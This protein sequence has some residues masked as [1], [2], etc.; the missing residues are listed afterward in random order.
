[1]SESVNAVEK[2]LDIL[3]CF[4]Q[5]E[6]VL[7]LTRI[8]EQVHLPKST[9][10]RHLITLENRHFLSRNENTG[11]YH[12]GLR[13]IEMAALVLRDSDFQR[14]THAHLQRLADATGETVD[15]AVLDGAHVV[16]LQVIE[17]PQR[18]KIAAAIG[19]R[20]PAY[21]TA[22]GKA[23]LAFLPGDRVDELLGQ[24]L[25]RYTEFTRV[26]QAAIH[27]DLEQTRVRGYAI[28]EQE[29][30]K[31]I[32]VV[33]APILD[34]VGYP[35]AAVAVA[36]PSF[37]LPPERMKKLGESILQTTAAIVSEGGI[38]ALSALI[39][40]SATPGLAGYTTKRGPV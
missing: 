2:A 28:S 8:A 15:L 9:V 34:A 10:H 35:V 11:M 13:F 1:M 25:V 6:P 38:T 33:A 21:C 16:D 30:E 29:Y 24:N 20:L 5:E 26:D 18:V 17:S 31:D 36:G 27:A 19:Q 4:S 40:N 22:S 32:N 39:S 12:L 23:F 37:R 7:S 3:L 14:W